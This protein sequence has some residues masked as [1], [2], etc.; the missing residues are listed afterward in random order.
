VGFCK[1][2]SSPA[3]GF[4]NCVLFLAFVEKMPQSMMLLFQTKKGYARNIAFF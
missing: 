3:L 4:P 1:K 2:N